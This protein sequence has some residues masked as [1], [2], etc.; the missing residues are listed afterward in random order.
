[1]HLSV[2]SKTVTLCPRDHLAFGGS[3]GRYGILGFNND[4]KLDSLIE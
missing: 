2:H 4:F 3:G 1:M